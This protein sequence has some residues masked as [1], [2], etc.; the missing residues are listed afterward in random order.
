MSTSEK[1]TD[2]HQAQRSIFREGFRELNAAN[3]LTLGASYASEIYGGH[4]APSINSAVMD[5]GDV[6][7][8]FGLAYSARQ[9][10]RG[11]HLRAARVRQIIYAGHI[12]LALFGIVESGRLMYEH[13]EPSTA[14]I[15]IAAA[16]GALNAG[17]VY[18]QRRRERTA[19][20]RPTDLPDLS[21]QA[22]E[23][24]ID[25]QV[26][27]AETNLIESLGNIGT[28][29]HYLLTVGSSVSIIASNAA[30]I[31]LL[32]RQYHREQQL[33]SALKSA[34]ETS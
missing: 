9:D 34:Q 23:M 24:N 6:A 29:S 16:S 15:A 20:V 26:T 13:Q 1:S 12:G 2:A 18:R 14:N 5:T 3:I 25:G 21:S 8:P 30:V 28:L 17:I 7:I 11:D 32:A 10:E 27:L 33:V 31:A 4:S 22:Y 19:H